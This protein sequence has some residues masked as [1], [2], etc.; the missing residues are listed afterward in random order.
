MKVIDNDKIFDIKIANSFKDR[1]LGLMFKKEINELILFPHCNAIH[2]FFMRNKIDIFFFD[3]NQE[4]STI[5]RN[6]K[7]NK[8]IKV[9]KAYY[10]L[11]T[12]INLLSNNIKLK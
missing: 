1:L 11:E 3:K 8:I 7:K 2:T 6:I 5:H 10:V 4:F 12:K 9:K